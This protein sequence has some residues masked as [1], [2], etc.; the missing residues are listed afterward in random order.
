MI[1]ATIF[2]CILSTLSPPNDAQFSVAQAKAVLKHDAQTL[3]EYERSPLP[4][5]ALETLYSSDEIGPLV[6]ADLVQQTLARRRNPARFRL[7][8]MACE[9]ANQQSALIV[10]TAM[11]GLGA[12]YLGIDAKSSEVDW[13]VARV[14]D[15]LIIHYFA[16]AGSEVLAQCMTDSRPVLDLLLEWAALQSSS[17]RHSRISA[18]ACCSILRIAPTL[19][20][21]R[22]YVLRA[23]T[24]FDYWGC[25]NTLYYET[26]NAPVLSTLR[27]KLANW[28]SDEPFPEIVASYL[29][30]VGDQAALSV[31]IEAE[32]DYIDPSALAD[33]QPNQLP[34]TFSWRIEVQGSEDRLLDAIRSGP[35]T[36]P[37]DTISRED[38][39][40]LLQRAQ[41]LAIPFPS[42]R[43]AILQ[44]M[45]QYYD[46]GGRFRKELPEVKRKAID[47]GIL[48][49]NDFAPVAAIPSPVSATTSPAQPSPAAP[50][51]RSIPMEKAWDYWNPDA[52]NYPALN[53]WMQSIDWESLPNDQAIQM[54]QEKM[55]ELDLTRPDACF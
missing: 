45:Q 5:I 19:E 13:E 27:N 22:E 39:M 41:D 18:L 26:A 52:S 42:I 10:I 40:W 12:S 53:D 14:M 8:Q 21:R 51:A 49:E 29:A 6:L 32:R 30:N 43:A 46:S 16:E 38:R 31:M 36:S 2:S 17:N 55:C 20:M 23:L 1:S 9:S 7:L 47:L 25:R 54:I 11:R 34:G 24:E 28:D 37:L 4:Y 48:E 35:G 44:Y 33:G 15:H 50:T 3:R